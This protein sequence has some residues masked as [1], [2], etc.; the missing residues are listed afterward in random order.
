MALASNR[1]TV[2]RFS[3][4]PKMLDEEPETGRLCS[5]RPML[6]VNSPV[7]FTNSFVPSSGS[8]N[9]KRPSPFG[10]RCVGSTDSSEMMGC[11]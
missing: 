8:T 5:M 4:S 1:Y 10:G 9:Q 7:P 2:D 6:T 11:W 3:L